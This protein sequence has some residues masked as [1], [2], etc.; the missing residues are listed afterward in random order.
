MTLLGSILERAVE[1]GKLQ[2]NPA[3]SVRKPPAHRRKG[4]RPL[5]PA[6]VE[7]IRQIFLHRGRVRDATLVSVPAYGGLRP[8]EALQA[9][10]P[11]P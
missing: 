8:S 11:P 7:R 6:E 1:W 3:R 10:F 5:S 4:I 9:R 2:Q